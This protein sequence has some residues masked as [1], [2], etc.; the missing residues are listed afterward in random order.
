MRSPVGL[1]MSSGTST[2]DFSLGT[3]GSLALGTPETFVLHNY[4][5]SEL[6]LQEI[7]LGGTHSADFL[8]DLIGTDQV[9]PGESREILIW[10][11]PM[12][13]GPRTATLSIT[14]T[15]PDESP[16]TIGLTGTGVTAAEAWRYHYFLTTADTGNAADLADPDQDGQINLLERAFNLHPLQSMNP[17]LTADTGITGLPLIRFIEEPGGSVFSIQY[18]R[19][20]SSANPGLIYTPQFNSDLMPPWQDV[21]GPETVESIDTEWERVT[22]QEDATGQL[23]RFGRVKVVSQ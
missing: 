4:G 5:S 2:Y 3:A 1:A 17:I 8:L 10:F 13:L 11:R 14:S 15:D 23:I 19:R 16:F 20:K 7:S 22:V 21:G 18:I 9:A 12:A 6:L